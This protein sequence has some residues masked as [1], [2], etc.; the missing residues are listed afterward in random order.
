MRGVIRLND[1]TSHGGKVISAAPN[2]TVMGVAVAR[3]GDQCVCPLPGHT[4]CIIAEGDP[5]VLV[6]GVPVAFDGHKTSCGATLITT[7]PGSGRG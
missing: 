4:V 2:S 7:V 5:K 3:K 1:P 6:D